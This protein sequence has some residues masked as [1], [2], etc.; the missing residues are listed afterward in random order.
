MQKKRRF[1]HILCALILATSLLLTAV[2][3]GGGGASTAPSAS[4]GTGG[5]ASSGGGAPVDDTV[6]NLSWAGIGG[7]DAIDTWIGEEAAR[8]IAEQTGDKVVITVYPASQLG[9]IT[10]AYDE[11]MQGTIDMGLFTI[12]GTYDMLCES[13]YTPF[14]TSNLDEFREVYGKEGFL[15]KA[16]DEVQQ[17]RGITLFGFWPSGY[18]G[19]VF[20]KMAETPDQLFSFDNTKS[21]LLRVPGMDTMMMSAQA[22]GYNVTTINYSDVYTSLQT[23]VCD[24]SWHGGAYSNYQSFRDVIK[25]YVDYRVCNDV[26]SLVMN[27]EKLESL[28]QEYQ[29]IV[30]KVMQEVLDEGITKIGEQESQS[31]KDL[32]DYGVEVI[33]PTDEQREYMKTYFIDNVWPQFAQFYGEE[34]MAQL[35]EAV[36]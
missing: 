5:S 33:T 32:E 29:D 15:Y 36:K 4:G 18:L 30:T 22:M 27:T 28:P 21:E 16:Y 31:L 10:Q 2:G 25:Y 1:L 26:Y 3:C 23:G 13:L 14:L 20:T 19:L 9:D 11:I 35:S 7:A 17:G 6:Y 24:G 12:Y 8:R 34:F